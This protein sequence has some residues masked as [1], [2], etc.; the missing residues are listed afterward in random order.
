[1]QNQQLSELQQEVEV[2]E[3]KYNAVHKL[4]KEAQDIQSSLSAENLSLKFEL[5]N[6]NAELEKCQR[7][8]QVYSL[9]CLSSYNYLGGFGFQFPS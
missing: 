6:V 9:I 7:H 3:D 8:L 1:M 5:A 4:L 2:L